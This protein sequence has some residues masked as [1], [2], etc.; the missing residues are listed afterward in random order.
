MYDHYCDDGRI[1]DSGTIIKAETMAKASRKNE[2]MRF[3]NHE[4]EIHDNVSQNRDGNP[5]HHA[6]QRYRQGLAHP[7][8]ADADRSRHQRLDIAFGFIHYYRVVGKN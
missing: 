8:L 4:A 5:Y 6:G 3:R 1:S 2:N 7:D